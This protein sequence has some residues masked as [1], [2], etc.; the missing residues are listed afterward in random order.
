M[1]SASFSQMFSFPV[2]DEIPSL[3]EFAWLPWRLGGWS[4]RELGISTL[5]RK[6]R[7]YPV[8]FPG[9]HC[10]LGDSPTKLVVCLCVFS[11]PMCSCVIVSDCRW[12]N[13]S[14]CTVA[15]SFPLWILNINPKQPPENFPCARP[16]LSGP[17][18]MRGWNLDCAR[19]NR[20]IRI[21][22][23]WS[24]LITNLLNWGLGSFVCYAL[25]LNT[26]IYSFLFR[27]VFYLVVYCGNK[28]LEEAQL[29]VTD[30]HSLIMTFYIFKNRTYK[31]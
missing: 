16:A 30:K 25:V 9:W 13:K 29:M 24:Y 20:S 2:I 14:H 11:V 15:H 1:K 5:G 26:N 27:F 8:Q 12:P 21:Q 28:S 4:D 7:G 3:L 31:S 23:L 18:H 19:T 22:D 17:A 6:L 10:F